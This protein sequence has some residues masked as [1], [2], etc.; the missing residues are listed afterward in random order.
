MPATH[1]YLDPVLSAEQRAED[2]LSR[3]S[4]E[5]KAGHSR[6]AESR[7]TPATTWSTT[8]NHSWP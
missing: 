2:L 3:M 6:T 5:D 1:P 8:S 4:P 7:S